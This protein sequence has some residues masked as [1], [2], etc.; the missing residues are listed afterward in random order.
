MALLDG[1]QVDIPFLG[2]IIAV[3]LGA[4][5]RGSQRH[6]C[7]AAHRAAQGRCRLRGHSS[8]SAGTRFSAGTDSKWNSGTSSGSGPSPAMGAVSSA[9]GGHILFKVG[10]LL[11]GRAAGNHLQARIFL[12][13]VHGSPGCGGWLQG[14]PR[15]A[16]RF[17]CRGCGGTAGSIALRGLRDRFLRRAAARR[18]GVGWGFA[19]RAGLAVQLRSHRAGLIG[20]I[21]AC[22]ALGRFEGSGLCRIAA[23]VQGLPAGAGR[24]GMHLWAVGPAGRGSGPGHPHGG[25]AA[26][27]TAR[28]CGLSIAHGGLSVFRCSA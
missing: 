4:A 19:A 14:A 11:F 28:C 25:V 1:Q 17:R 12:L 7:A 27:T 18:L 3:A 24:G 8:S 22:R 9:V 20:I 16:R 2:H 26:A 23:V 6:Q 10:K 15:R 5:Q 13:A 21:G